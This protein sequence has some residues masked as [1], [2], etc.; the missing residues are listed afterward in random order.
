MRPAGPRFARIPGLHAKTTP[1]AA[2]EPRILAH[3][4]AAPAR[5]GAPRARRLPT[6]GQWL[7]I[8]VLSLTGVAAFGLAPDTTLETIPTR[9]VE[10]PLPLPALAPADDD[11]VY[12]REERVQRGDTIGSLLARAGVDDAG[13]MQFLRTDPAARPLYQLRPGR[14][15]RVAVDADGALLALRFHTNAGDMLAIERGAENAFRAQRTAVTEDVRTTL[16]TGEIRS[17]LFGAADAAGIPDAVTVALADVF[18][19]DID[20]YHDLRRGDRFGVVYEERF[21]DGEPVGTGRILAAEFENR[22]A[23]LRVFL[24]RDPEGNEAYFTESGRS[25]RGAFLNRRWSSRASRRASR[26][27]ASTRSCS[28]G[29]RT[30]AS[31]TRRRPARRCARPPTASSRSRAVRA[32]TAT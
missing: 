28:S 30:R 6:P 23:L 29:A 2:D 3:P 21:V 22:G 16:R 19:G 20:F 25:A 24:W 8:V 26:S 10:R 1:L 17:S 7:A 13:A 11:A 4:S 9:K 12:W 15:V 14:P 5:P 27:R 18:A 31:T 32:A